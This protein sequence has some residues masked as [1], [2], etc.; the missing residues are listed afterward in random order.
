MGKW[1]DCFYLKDLSIYSIK[2]IF[3]KLNSLLR[4]RREGHRNG[5]VNLY[6]DMEPFEENDDI[7]VMWK[8][9]QVQSSTPQCTCTVK[10]TNRCLLETMFSTD[11]KF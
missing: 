11:L 3:R 2:S 9:I 4:F 10:R 6:K 7:Q 1:K 8:M 5:L